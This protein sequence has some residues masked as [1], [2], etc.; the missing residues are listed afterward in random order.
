MADEYEEL[1]SPPD[2]Y[3]EPDGYEAPSELGGPRPMS[4]LLRPASQLSDA[5]P[6][7][8]EADNEV[9]RRKLD[10]DTKA[11]PGFIKV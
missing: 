8:V 10:P 5:P 7:V 9:G 2:G 6:P 4:N 11:P 1:T 3:E